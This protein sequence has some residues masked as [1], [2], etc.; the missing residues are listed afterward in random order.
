LV[1]LRIRTANNVSQKNSTKVYGLINRSE[2]KV[3]LLLQA[4]R[5]KG[6]IPMVETRSHDYARPHEREQKTGAAENSTNGLNLADILKDAGP[7]ALHS[8]ESQPW[9]D[10]E[11]G[12]YDRYDSKPNRSSWLE[13]EDPY[14]DRHSTSKAR[15]YDHASSDHG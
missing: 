10:F 5:R 8:P 14:A 11:D 1:I 9:R 4:A 7:V 6:G 13:F 12:Y 2:F 3:V 15:I